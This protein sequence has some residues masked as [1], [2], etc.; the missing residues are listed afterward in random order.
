MAEKL[1]RMLIM[2]IPVK[3]L[4]MLY[5]ISDEALKKYPQNQLAPKFYFSGHILL[6]EQ[7]MK[8]LLKKN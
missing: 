4:M 3:N 2:L 7:V 5:S 8:E 1:I 6:A